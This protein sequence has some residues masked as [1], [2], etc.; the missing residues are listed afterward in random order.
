MS[1]GSRNYTRTFPIY[2]LVWVQCTSLFSH[3]T[4]S[5]FLQFKTFLSCAK[6]WQVVPNRMA[7]YTLGGMSAAQA[8][9][10]HELYWIP[11]RTVCWLKKEKKKRSALSI[12][13]AKTFLN[14]SIT[15]RR[16]QC[17]QTR[18]Q[19]SDERQACWKMATIWTLNLCQRWVF[20][21]TT[22]VCSPSIEFLGTVLKTRW[23]VN[24]QAARFSNHLKLSKHFVTEELFKPTKT[25]EHLIVKPVMQYGRG[26][27]QQFI[28]QNTSYRSE[29]RVRCSARCAK[30]PKC[31]SVAM[32]DDSQNWH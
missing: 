16:A 4:I 14:S 21:I 20:I 13:S 25:A 12:W 32:N 6:L 15:S 9:P 19:L 29:T 8:Q 28:W 18:P 24:D 1:S 5:S 3:K 27:M 23:E 10:F 2:L 30:F 26:C 17:V 7:V 22:L 31:L 11:S